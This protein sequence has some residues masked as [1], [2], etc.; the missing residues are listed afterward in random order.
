MVL[1]QS[2][3]DL[4]NSVGFSISIITTETMVIILNESMVRAIWSYYPLG[5]KLMSFYLTYSMFVCHG[6]SLFEKHITLDVQ[7]SR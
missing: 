4:I 3:H 5:K 6:S 7:T 1:K 2:L